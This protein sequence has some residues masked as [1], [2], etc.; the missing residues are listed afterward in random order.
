VNFIA[1]ETRQKLRGGYYT[2]PEIARYLL[3]WVL[4]AKP[5]T[6]LEPSCG[7]GVFLR[8]LGDSDVEV[9]AVELDPNEAIE[10]RRAAPAARVIEGDYLAW[11]L[12]QL[13]APPMFDAVVGNPPFIRYQ[14]LDAQVQARSEQLIRGFSLRFTKHTNA[15]V[16]FVIGALA[17]LRPGGRLAMVIPSELLHILHAG[18]AREFLLRSCSRV[19][20]LDPDELWFPEALQG[21]VLLL[22]T[23]RRVDEVAPC[24]L[25]VSRIEGKGDLA[26][27]VSQ[28]FSSADGVAMETGPGKWMLA[29]LSANERRLIRGLD[30]L[31]TVARFDD[32]AN[33]QVGIVTGANKFF[34][35]DD[36]VV[37]AYGLQPYVHPMFGRSEHVRGV[38]YDADEHRH[39]KDMG[40]RSNF[41]WLRDE[42][43][44]HGPRTYVDLGEQQS[45]HTR[46][47]C[48][49]RSPWYAVPSVFTA[50]VAMLKRAHELP[51]LVLNELPAY[52]TDTAY[53]ITP[54]T[55]P[56]DQ[57]V[58]SFVTSL[59]ALS[60]ELE[61]RHYAGG[62]LELVPSE[63]RQLRIAVTPTGSAALVE[64]DRAF[65]A[66]LAVPDLL[67]EQ[68]RVILGALGLSREDQTVLRDAWS[69]LRHRRQRSKTG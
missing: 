14:Y 67:T 15:W 64:L 25:T 8:A 44:G 46:Y 9:T 31:P 41:V 47:K 21:V 68:D 30:A 7:D 38:I 5:R 24:R 6:V 20:V 23:R 56:A 54:R 1:N 52:T 32:L 4:Q 62:V 63:I 42:A 33:V 3:D 22:A 35:V 40:R 61:G 58:G 39:N 51:R 49:I 34:L 55:V 43:V 28:R 18:A 11:A 66:R 45:L 27:P 26:V 48:R 65:R 13:D 29:L 69:R 37:Q 12:D 50:P 59:T 36:E 60:A 19:L 16:P 10:A 57:L 2:D 53:R 17:Q